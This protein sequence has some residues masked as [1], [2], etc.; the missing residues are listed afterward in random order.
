MPK[1]KEALERGKGARREQSEP[2]GNG[3]PVRDF[4]V[5][6]RAWLDE[7][8]IATLKA[9]QAEVA[10]ELNID[11]DAGSLRSKRKIPSVRFKIYKKQ[12]RGGRTFMAA[13]QVD[14]GVSVSAPGIVARDAGN[15]GDRSAERFSN[16]IAELIEDV[17]KSD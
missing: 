15:I 17:A 4:E 14:G 11:I 13:V 2:R 5:E 6:A 10:D 3:A 9:A 12:D 16:L 1:F 7:I 8:V